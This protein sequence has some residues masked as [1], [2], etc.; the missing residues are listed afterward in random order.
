MADSP[1]ARLIGSW[2]FEPIL[3]SGSPGRGRATFEWIEAGAFVGAD[4]DEFIA[5]AES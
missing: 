5:A 3:E 2:E 1:L 4:A